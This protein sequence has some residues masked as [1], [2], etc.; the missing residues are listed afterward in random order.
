MNAPL[1]LERACNV[2]SCFIGFG[3]LLSLRPVPAHAHAQRYFVQFTL[4][5]CYKRALIQNALESI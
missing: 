3:S 4:A 2:G 1:V 5:L